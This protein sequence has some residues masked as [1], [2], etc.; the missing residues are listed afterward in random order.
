MKPQDIVVLLSIGSREPGTWN[1]KTLAMDLVISPAEIGYSLKRS[2]Q[3]GLL[4]EDR[5]LMV[6]SFVDMLG[7]AVRF[8]FPA[9]LGNQVRGVPTAWSASPLKDEI[10]SSELIVWPY[11]LGTV[12]GSA[13]SPLYPT[14]PEVALKNARMHELLAM[15]DALR[16]GGARERALA[17]KGLSARLL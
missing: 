5:R 4:S 2:V 9:S 7:H 3:C 11:A 16:I 13:L 6:R 12:R 17:I 8:V 15:V 14:V 1:A 10:V